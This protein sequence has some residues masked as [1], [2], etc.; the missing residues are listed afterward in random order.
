M[1]MAHTALFNQGGNILLGNPAA[2]HDFD[3]IA[4]LLLKRADLRAAVVASR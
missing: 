4:K 3:A 2:S 1:Y